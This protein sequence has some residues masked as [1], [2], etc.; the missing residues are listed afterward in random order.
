MRSWR[1]YLQK[2]IVF[3]LSWDRARRRLSRVSVIVERIICMCSFADS[4]VANASSHPALT[5]DSIICPPVLTPPQGHT[6]HIVVMSPNSQVTSCQAAHLNTQRGPTE[7]V[8]L[9]RVK[10]V[11]DGR[12]QPTS[13]VC[14]GAVVWMLFRKAQNSLELRWALVHVGSSLGGRDVNYEEE[15]FQRVSVTI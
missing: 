11:G 12:I 1:N 13:T 4:A 10:Q 15:N 8:F 2:S 7:W 5:C 3:S 14:R 9:P 6:W